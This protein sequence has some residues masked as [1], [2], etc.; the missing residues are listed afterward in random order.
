MD[1]VNFLKVKCEMFITASIVLFRFQKTFKHINLIQ[2]TCFQVEDIKI[3][4]SR[5][6]TASLKQKKAIFQLENRLYFYICW[7]EFPLTF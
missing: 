6:D 2:V 3:F 1:L 7:K 4:F 5:T